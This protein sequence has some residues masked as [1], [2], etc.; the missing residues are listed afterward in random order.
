[1]GLVIPL[2]LI[3]F[4]S[5]LLAIAVHMLLPPAAD[6]AAHSEP[7]NPIFRVMGLLVMVF[8]VVKGF[9]GARS[10]LE[11]MNLPDPYNEPDSQAFADA[12]GTV[13]WGFVILTIGA[14]IWRGAKRRGVLDRGGRLAIIA[15]YLL[16]G[17]ALSEAIDV[18]TGIL[19]P[20]TDPD[21]A[22]PGDQALITFLAWGA[23][24]AAIVRVGTWLAKEK[25]LL[26]A[27]FST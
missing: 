1:M 25:I 9:G 26:I 17:V 8:G 19:T 23:P 27:R 2:A 22:D 4:G 20:S 15:G 21:A 18:G 24:G 3:I 12:D 11:T 13:V 6:D 7:A 14:Y 5:V 16:V 10:V